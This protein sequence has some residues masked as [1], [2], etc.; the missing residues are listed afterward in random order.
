MRF[1]IILALSIILAAC[2]TRASLNTQTGEIKGLESHDVANI[3]TNRDYVNAKV[4]APQKAI[5]SMKAHPGQQITINAAEFTV[6]QPTSPADDIKAPAQAKST[7]ERNTAAV[8]GLLKDATPIVLGGMALSDRKDARASAERIAESEAETERARDAAQAEQ[9]ASLI[10][11]LK[12]KPQVIFA[13]P[14]AAPTT[15]APAE[16]APVATP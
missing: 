3:V 8:G 10:Q 4:T 1:I 11:G 15:P 5:V 6:W 14:H 12:E 2:G 9:N 16:P 13:T 7:F